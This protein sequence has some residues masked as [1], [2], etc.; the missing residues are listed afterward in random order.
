[1]RNSSLLA[2]SAYLCVGCSD[3]A[4]ASES[5][6]G[7][8]SITSDTGTEN[9]DSNAAD[10]A[11]GADAGSGSDVSVDSSASDASVGADASPACKCGEPGCCPGVDPVD[12]CAGATCPVKHDTGV[13]GSYWYCG[14]LGK[15]GDATT[16]NKE[17]AE[18]A[19]KAWRPSGSLNA[20]SCPAGVGDAIENLDGTSSKALW[21]YS[22]SSAGRAVSCI[23]GGSCT[24][25]TPTSTMTWN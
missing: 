15:P 24:C 6:R 13:G 10:D 7:D 2:L 23:S 8:A 25:P 4:P 18:R 11:P 12:C 5:S 17:M 22:G 9:S 1:M 3:P 19:A 20:L 14:P 16:Y 21:V